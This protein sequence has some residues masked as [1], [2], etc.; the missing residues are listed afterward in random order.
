V[1]EAAG[2]GGV[3]DLDEDEQYGEFEDDEEAQFEDED[4]EG[5]KFFEEDDTLEASIAVTQEA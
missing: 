3:E 1:K 4:L 5:E 2:R